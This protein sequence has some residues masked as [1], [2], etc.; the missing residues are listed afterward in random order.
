MKKS[1]AILTSILSLLCTACGE[2]AYS[3]SSY[4]EDTGVCVFETVENI[5]ELADYIIDNRYGDSYKAF[6]HSAQK[7]NESEF[8]MY[9]LENIPTGYELDAIRAPEQSSLITMNYIKSE[10]DA[11]S[12]IT[13]VWD[14]K[15]NG[16]AFFQ[17][18][19]DS[20][21]LIDFPAMPGYY[22]VQTVDDFQQNIYQIYWVEDGYKFQANIP[23]SL[24]SDS[25]EKDVAVLSGEKTP[26][27]FENLLAL[28]KQDYPIE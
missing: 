4:T 2:V 5:D 27:D 23:V 22:Y 3:E 12:K 25:E 10:G 6:N 1:I 8:T 20:L 19:I 18:T 9:S 21:G 11:A 14:Y 26:E 7:D 13:F 24:F 15:N 16:E 28:E 17:D